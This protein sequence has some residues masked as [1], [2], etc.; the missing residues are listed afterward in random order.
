[1]IQKTENYFTDSD[2]C[3]FFFR[4]FIPE[5]APKANILVVH[6]LSDHSGRFMF[7]GEKLAEQGYLVVIPDLRGNGLST[8]IR[9]HFDSGSQMLYDVTFFI[10]EI[11][12]RNDAPVMLYGQ[13][14]GGNIVLAY[15]LNYPRNIKAVIASSPWLRLAKP[16]AK[17][18][19]KIAPFLAKMLPKIKITNGLK[20][21]DLTHNKQI[22]AAYDNDSLIHWKITFSTFFYISK[23]GE[24]AIAGAGNIK[25]P[26]LLMHGDS[27]KITSFAASKELMSNAGKNI[28]FV[29]WIG[30]FHELH[31]ESV[32]EE[33]LKT[34][35]NWLNG[36][37]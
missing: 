10:E 34:V 8:G 20:S 22:A 30:M 25:I 37:K 31:N 2:G 13:S 33:V 9:G 11:R 26:V 14:M 18:L 35:A 5:T 23:Q 12:K 36:L 16:P 4:E 7:V 32:K 21:N 15:A 24:D 6:G 27:D 28:T 3:R 1:M 29:P 19:I 17:I